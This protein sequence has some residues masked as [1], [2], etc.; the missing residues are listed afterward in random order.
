MNKSLTFAEEN[1]ASNAMDLLAATST[2][3]LV[4]HQWLITKMRSILTG[5]GAP[6]TDDLYQFEHA[7]ISNLH[8]PDNLLQSF[9]LLKHQLESVWH[10]TVKIHHPLSGQTIFEQ[11]NA[12]QQQAHAFMH[13][14][15]KF[16]DKS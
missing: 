16:N 15:K 4:R 14:T 6:P 1:I 8:L 5:E 13:E 9:T 2:W 3:I 11:L 7:F 12:Y 10:E